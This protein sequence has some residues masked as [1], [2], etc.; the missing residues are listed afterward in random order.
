MK[1]EFLPDG[2]DDCPLVRLYDF[3]RTDVARLFDGLTALASRERDDIAVHDLPGVEAVSGCRL[4]LRNGATNRGVVRLPGP[5]SFT[6]ILTRESWDNV[7]GL[8]EPFM[9]ET[10]GYQWL[11]ASGDAKWLLST[12]GQW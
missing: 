11:I 1:L 8:A 9:R 10:R 5:A 7:A 4:L 3:D 6:C 2:S 12:D